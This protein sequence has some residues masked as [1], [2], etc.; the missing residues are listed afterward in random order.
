LTRSSSVG[1]GSPASLWL[2][3]IPAIRRPSVEH[4]KALFVRVLELAREMGLL[5][6]AGRAADRGDRS[7]AHRRSKGR[8]NA[9]RQP[10]ACLNVDHST[11][12][13]GLRATGRDTL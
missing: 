10:L 11:T 3:R 7:R 8:G 6:M 2:Y 12:R 13:V 4:L 9:C 1:G 5:R